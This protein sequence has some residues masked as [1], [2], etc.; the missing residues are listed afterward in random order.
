V[1]FE[2]GRDFTFPL[3]QSEKWCNGS[4]PQTHRNQRTI[5]KKD[6]EE[7]ECR[8]KTRAFD[9]RGRR[10]QSQFSAAKR[11]CEFLDFDRST[12]RQI[13]GKEAAFLVLAPIY[14]P[15]GG[16]TFAFTLPLQHGDPYL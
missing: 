11:D 12:L 5:G 13:S 16:A 4:G 7:S 2:E 10:L 3:D 15:E 6:F 14:R 8:M 1:L 9:F